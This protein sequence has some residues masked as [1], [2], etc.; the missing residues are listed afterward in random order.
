[1][2]FVM[3]EDEVDSR[4]MLPAQLPWE[5]I[6]G[7]GL[8]ESWREDHWVEPPRLERLPFS[9]LYHQTM[10]TLASEGELTPAELARRV[11][12]LS[13]FRR[14]SPQ[15]YRTLLLH[16][17]DT[18]HIQRTE[19]GGL[20]IGLA[21][22]RVTSGFKFYAVFQENE[23]YSVRADGQELGTL[24]Q[25]PPAGEK[26]AIAGRVW[27]V[28]EV[29]PKRHIV[30]CRL[31][32]GRV[33]AFFGLCPGDIHTHILEKT[34]EVLC[35]DTDY[36]YLMPNA[37]KRLAQA[38]SLAQ[39]S[40]MTTTPLINLGGSFWA[41]FP[42]LGTYPFLALERLI[43]IHAAADIGLT[44]FETS[45][46]WFIVLRM[47][48]SAPAF[49]RALADAADRVQDPM[50]YLYPDEVPLF[51]KYDEALPAE[52][53]RKGFA[54]GVLGIDEMR[55][56]VKSWAGAF[57]GGTESAAKLPAEDGRQLSGSPQG[58]AP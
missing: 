17:L 36:P 9:L 13:P 3:R 23:E 54:C 21:G 7:I 19:R 48:A 35:S 26:I 28:E 20:I 31:T 33:P 32:E 5:L 34:C 1:M 30:W 10:A 52:L 47:K 40:G 15:D 44:N 53:V 27:E 24:V 46:P 11:L 41:L 51:E 43:R 6:H 14:I 39:H 55:A 8:V 42:W 4:E 38:R 49:F 56:R 58:A 16:L 2:R 50:S 45:R 25:P 22:E 37:R 29:D 18:D 57:Q 12:T